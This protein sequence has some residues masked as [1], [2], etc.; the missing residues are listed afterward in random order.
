MDSCSCRQ[1]KDR[2]FALVSKRFHGTWHT[3]RALLSVVSVIA[4]GTSAGACNVPVFRYALERWQSDD[5]KL[6][7]YQ[8]GPIDKVVNQ[9]QNDIATSKSNIEL[10]LIDL[11]SPSSLDRRVPTLAGGYL[12]DSNCHFV[13]RTPDQQKVA[14]QG[15]VEA[16]SAS[17]LLDSP[18]RKEL[19]RRLISGHAIVW[20]VVQSADDMQ[21]KETRQLLLRTIES[22]ADRIELP[23]GIGL[24]GSEL[25]SEVP[26]LLRFSV[27]EIEPRDPNETFLR[28]LFSLYDTGPVVVPVFG[29]GRALEVIP[30]SELTA[31]MIGDLTAYLC[32][33]CSCQVKE[34]NPGFDLL[35][36]TDWERKLF[37]D[38]GP[39]RSE[40]PGLNRSP[41]FLTIPPGKSN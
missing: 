9:F 2:W 21:N 6:T 3:H 4:F 31:P 8:Q 39:P 23:E 30:A 22:M 40:P 16:N 28:G 12:K 38:E 19:S 25:H 5:Y 1:R 41:K 37:G 29:R 32:G 17:R 10:T 14:L 18:V 27:L 35:L 34:R 15:P 36:T 13:I 24:P 26:L 11:A 33:A 20:L 7:I